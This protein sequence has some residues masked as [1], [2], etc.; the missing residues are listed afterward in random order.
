MD[1]TENW[2][3]AIGDRVKLKASVALAE[4]TVSPEI[5]HRTGIVCRE[6]F[7]P[8]GGRT[9]GAFCVGVNWSANL[10]TAYPRVEDLELVEKAMSDTCDRLA[11]ERFKREEPDGE[12]ISHAQ[13]ANEMELERDE[14]KKTAARWKQKYDRVLVS[15]ASHEKEQQSVIDA[16]QADFGKQLEAQQKETFDGA[17]RLHDEIR[18]LTER[19]AK[20]GTASEDLARE[21][22]AWTGERSQLKAE[23]A[24][25]NT[26]I[27]HYGTQRKTADEKA[28]SSE[29]DRRMLVQSICTRL[30][31]S[32]PPSE[33]TAIVIDSVIAKRLT[34]LATLKTRLSEAEHEASVKVGTGG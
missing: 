11:D 7:I 10:S 8:A 14:W 4:M 31:I 24:R 34:E 3:P 6:P 33:R 32:T 20:S 1:Q 17:K 5:G 21:R 9:T 26:S 13:R 25:L 12:E 28:I 22:L 23:I 29:N 19:L 30:G 2:T 15:M 27:E 16:V 18:V